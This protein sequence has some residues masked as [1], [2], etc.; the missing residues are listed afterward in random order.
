MNLREDGI[1]EVDAKIPSD[2]QNTCEVL[3]TKATF[4]SAFTY[5]QLGRYGLTIGNDTLYIVFCTLSFSSALVCAGSSSIMLYYMDSLP[6]I[7]KRM[8]FC[9]DVRG[10]QRNFS[11]L[12]LFAGINY[13]LALSRIGWAYYPNQPIRYFSLIVMIISVLIFIYGFNYVIKMQLGLQFHVAKDKFDITKNKEINLTDYEKIRANFIDKMDVKDIIMNFPEYSER[14]GDKYNVYFAKESNI[15]ATRALF[16]AGLTQ[17]GMMRFSSYTPL[18]SYLGQLFVIFSTI[19][20]A[21]SLLSGVLLIW[22]NVFLVDTESEKQLAFSILLAPLLEKMLKLYTISYVCIALSIFMMGYGI[23]CLAS[24]MLPTGYIATF[25]KFGIINVLLISSVAYGYYIKQS[26]K[27]K[28]LLAN[29]MKRDNIEDSSIKDNSE[30]NYYLNIFKDSMLRNNSA[31]GMSVF[32]CNYVFFNIVSF[33]TN[34]YGQSSPTD[35]NVYSYNK[36]FLIVNGLTLIIGLSSAIIDSVQTMFCNEF[37]EPK[38]RVEYLSSTIYL[39]NIVVYGYRLTFLGWFTVFSL[40]GF[41]KTGEVTYIPLIYSIIGLLS[42]IIGAQYL[43]YKF[44][45]VQNSNNDNETQKIDKQEAHKLIKRPQLLLTIAYSVFFLGGF[46]YYGVN[47]LVLQGRMG[48]MVY[49]HALCLCFISSIS[50]IFWSNDYN[51]KMTYCKSYNDKVYFAQITYGFFK[52]YLVIGAVV[53]ISILVGFAYLGNIKVI[54]NYEEV[55]NIV[56]IGSIVAFLFICTVM[57]WVI[58]KFMIIINSNEIVEGY[59][60][61][62]I[63]ISKIKHSVVGATFVAS[64]VCYEL[65]FSQAL[66]TPSINMYYFAM[67]TICLIAGISATSLT[68]FIQV[69]MDYFASENKKQMFANKIL[70]M[71]NIIFYLMFICLFCWLCG[72]IAMGEVK[73]KYKNNLW[74]PVSLY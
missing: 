4:L 34:V 57:V 2:F 41:V 12:F 24:S 27:A 38:D 7:A 40:F 52:F 69:L 21:T 16:I 36:A 5:Y 23:N 71:K 63:F 26:M 25:D 67:T 13:M 17:N 68:I 58:K 53:L 18:D 14:I 8:L 45:L 6:T 61:Y 56:R 72:C 64:W 51:N 62:K 74:E 1:S 46:A 10:Y 66:S 33:T 70:K 37:P 55:M 59:Y 31:G 48:E 30:D 20:T 43:S 47:F 9:E 22:A 35:T 15:I 28:N 65:L 39:S 19:S 60:D 29:V 44:R 32:A 50:C 54:S 3:G 73:Y 42:S 49:L 11:K